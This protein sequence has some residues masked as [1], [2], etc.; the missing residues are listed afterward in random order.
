MARYRPKVY[1]FKVVLMDHGALQ[2]ANHVHRNTDRIAFMASSCIS[3]SA[4]HFLI[5]SGSLI[6]SI[7]F[8]KAASPINSQARAVD[9]VLMGFDALDFAGQ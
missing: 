7:S 3:A 4:S 2:V 1:L 6:G 8:R 9:N 5:V